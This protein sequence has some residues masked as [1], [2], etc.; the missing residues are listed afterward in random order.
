MYCGYAQSYVGFSPEN[1]SGINGAVLNPASIADSRFRLDV[2]L[3]SLSILGGS[4][5][6]GTDFFKLALNSQYDFEQDA[7][8]FVKEDNNFY[9]NLDILGPSVMFNI[10]DIYS[11]GLIT[12]ARAFGNI[13]RL[14][15]T[16]FNNLQD[17]L[18]GSEDFM[19]DE[20]DTNA[21]MHGWG[22]IGV[23]FGVVLLNKGLNF[24]KGGFTLKYLQAIGS[25]SFDAVEVNVDYSAS[26]ETLTT[27]GDANLTIS[28]GLDENEDLDYLA[29]RSGTGLD[30]GFI[31]EYRPQSKQY[32]NST[33]KGQSEPRRDQNKYRFRLGVSVTDIGSSLGY[34]EATLRNYDLNQSI[35]KAD[36]N[37]GET[38]DALD[39]EFLIG[40]ARPR[41][42]KIGLPTAMHVN[43]DWNLKPKWYLNVNTDI[44]L[45]GAERINTNRKINMVTATPRYESRHIGVTMPISLRQ[46]GSTAIGAGLRL[47]PLFIG[48]GSIFSNL[49]SKKSKTFDVYAGLRFYL[50]HKPT[51]K[52]ENDEDEDGVNDDEDKCPDVPGLPEDNGCPKTDADGDGVIDSEDG[53]P[54]ESG[55]VSLGGCPD[56]D[57]DGVADTDDVCP[58]LAGTIDKDGCPESAS[59]VVNRL[60]EFAKILLFNTAQ[61]TFMDSSFDTLDTIVEILKE[62][63]TARFSIE[64]HTDSVGSESSNMRLSIS[65]ANAVRDYLISKGIPDTQIEAKGFGE[66]QPISDNKTKTGR[67]LN[68][69]VTVNLIAE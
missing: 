29:G 39:R 50:L 1:Y 48:S 4:D 8:I 58:E 65:R 59:G 11:I 57:G 68:R 22:E 12:R 45:R 66:S 53:C 14:N 15:G 30:V 21:T 44:S 33:G 17:K 47:G 35:S 60:N 46:Y 20:G 28:D 25:A 5:A 38:L 37:N 56:T 42:I 52:I 16:T 9:G 55:E 49:I 54:Y 41:D 10:N 32:F 18:D 23:S 7:T 2:N 13:N 3:G 34:D 63:P 27:T 67:A 24:I 43:L 51:E 64:G 40:E 19:V 69:R 26:S 36:L 62:Y 61:A 31:Y 6:V